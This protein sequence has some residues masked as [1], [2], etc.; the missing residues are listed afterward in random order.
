[1]LLTFPDLPPTIRTPIWG[2]YIDT[3]RPHCWLRLFSTISAG[4]P[5][6]DPLTCTRF[7]GSDASAGS[8]ALTTALALP[9]GPSLAAVHIGDEKCLM[10]I[11]CFCI[12]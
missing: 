9:C 6:R 1:M 12:A 7:V 5:R 2:L 4:K 11:A 10:K 3:R 8:V